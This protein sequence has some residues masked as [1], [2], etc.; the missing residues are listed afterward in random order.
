MKV[1]LI[2]PDQEKFLE[3]KRREHRKGDKEEGLVE[4]GE[5]TTKH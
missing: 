5:T 3:Q 4:K 1:N 2:N